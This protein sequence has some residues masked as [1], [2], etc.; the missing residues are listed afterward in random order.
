[1][2]GQFITL[3]LNICRIF[4]HGKDF[5][6]ICQPFPCTTVS[7]ASAEIFPTAAMRAV[8]ARPAR[9]RAVTP[10]PLRGLRQCPNDTP[11]D[12]TLTLTIHH[13]TCSRGTRGG[14]CGRWHCAPGRWRRGRSG[15][16]RQR[17][18]D[19]LEAPDPEAFALVPPDGAAV[20][21]SES[22]VVAAAG[23]A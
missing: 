2:V 21:T 6:G 13:R 8:L 23:R 12:G 9:P 14:R 10:A 5:I 22:C 18:G 16:P 3:H 15:S 19:R 1:M 11:S 20:S 17:L 4:V 7:P